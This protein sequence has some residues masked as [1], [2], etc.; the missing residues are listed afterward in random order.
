MTIADM[1]EI[2]DCQKTGLRRHSCGSAVVMRY[3]P[4]CTFIYCLQ[5]LCSVYAVADW[6]PGECHSGWN[7]L[8]PT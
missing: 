5:C 7:T 8:S 1:I 4:G 3:E 6:E 2:W